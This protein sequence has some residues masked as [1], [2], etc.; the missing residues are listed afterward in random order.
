[1]A[2]AQ[3]RADKRHALE[4]KNDFN[5][6]AHEER[7]GLE[8]LQQNQQAHHDRLSEMDGEMKLVTM[9]HPGGN[10]LKINACNLDDI[11]TWKRQGYTIVDGEAVPRKV[12][13]PEKYKKN[14]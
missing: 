5:F 14:D 1:M 10:V 8:V 12:S 6:D 13:V 4:R 9:K 11:A 7:V 2:S 3:K